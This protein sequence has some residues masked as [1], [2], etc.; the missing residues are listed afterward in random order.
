IRTREGMDNLAAAS[1]SKIGIAYHELG[2]Y[3]IA[4]KYQMEALRYY[5][6]TND[7]IR[8]SQT[9]TNLARAFFE[10][11][12]FE[13]AIYYD[14][15]ALDIFTRYNYT[16][17][18]ATTYGSLA[19]NYQETDRVEKA[20]TYLE[21][22]LALFKSLNDDYNAATVLLNLGQIN[23]YEGDT[24]KGIE[25]YREAIEIAKKTGDLHTY[26]MA[27]ANLANCFMDIDRTSEA[28]KL[29]L[30]ALD[31]AKEIQVLKV[32]H[33]CYRELANLY[34][35]TGRYK[36]ALAFK[37][38]QYVVNDSIYNIEKYEQLS[39][40]EKKYE[41]EKKEQQI[42]ILKV[43]NEVKKLTIKRQKNL[44]IV[45]IAGIVL[46]II[47]GFLWYNRKRLQQ[48]ATLE[49]EKNKYRKKLLEA[50]I[51]AEEK[52]RKRIAGELHD[53]VAQQLSGLK[54]AWQVISKELKGKNFE[55]LKEITLTLDETSDEIR[56]LSH[57]M[58]PKVLTTGGLI[59]AIED[60]LSKSLK[61]SRIKY[62]FEHFGIESS[63]FDTKIELSLYR[64]CQELINNVI[65]HSEADF[66]SVQLFK[67][68]NNL[69]LMLED[70]GK[71]MKSDKKKQGI[72]LL[73]I[74]S[75]I[76]TVNGEINYQPGPDSGTVAT[77]KIPL[78]IA[79]KKS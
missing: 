65:K 19:L 40:L 4:A 23:R 11:D 60:M 67:S 59:Y 66:V 68:S 46:L 27:L 22:S 8:M 51:D 18:M 26:S 36:E 62:E 69:I 14:E 55:K 17:G 24:Q 38:K 58:M 73:N 79:K 47:I 37:S 43:K 77:I 50:S 42:E 70:N 6:K 74:A 29:Y 15:K 2:K 49:A 12:D 56:N 30:E 41:S 1:N 31:I 44:I 25:Y 72:G 7:S 53:G 5:E 13:K 64:V 61:Y 20:I 75:R 3:D 21:K 9:F 63:R 16:Y 34:E 48:K 71:G 78:E 52:E 76:D 39:D 54:M 28:E 33:Q 45:T 10:N 57:Q 32:E 35:K